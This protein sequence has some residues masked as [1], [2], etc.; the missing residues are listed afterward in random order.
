MRAAIIIGA[1]IAIYI[2]YSCIDKF[3]KDVVAGQRVLVTGGSYGIGEQLAYEY[4]KLGASVV[5]TARTE[6]LLQEVVE[7]CKSLGPKGNTYA[8]I[9]ADMSNTAETGRVIKESVAVLGGLDTLVLNHY[10]T[11]QLNFW[12]GTPQNFTMLDRSFEVD[13]KSYVHLASHALPYLEASRGSINVVNSIAGRTPSPQM[14][15]YAATKAALTGFF[16]V[17][18]QELKISKKDVSVTVCTLG[19]IGTPG[20]LEQ[21]RKAGVG[22]LIDV[23]APPPP[24][25]C[26]LAMIKSTALRER[27]MY[28]P[29]SAW[30]IS[31][32]RDWWPELIDAMWMMVEYQREGHEEL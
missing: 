32:P 5:I 18:R 13:F 28:Y 27:H 12:R 7:N 23:F 21:L 14:A 11:V 9:V 29:L 25:D 24:A 8:Y 22:M 17:L 30:F 31:G 6:H 3:D 26:A 16:T 10:A 2:G 19:V 4:A 1:L 15:T 20:S